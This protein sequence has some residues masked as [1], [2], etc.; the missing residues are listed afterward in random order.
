MLLKAALMDGAPAQ[1]CWKKWKSMVDIDNMDG[2]SYRLIPLLHYNLTQLGVQDNI[3]PR[4][5]GISRYH[6][7]KNHILLE[8][9]SSLLKMLDQNNIEVMLLKGSALINQYYESPA[10]RPMSDIDIMV[11]PKKLNETIA[12]LKNSGWVPTMDFDFTDIR[13]QRARHSQEYRD[14]S[15]SECDLHWTP[16]SSGTWEGAELRFW[17]TSQE[18]ILNGISAR[19]LGPT[20]QLFHI[21]IHGGHYNIFPAI[22]WVADS[23][24]ILNKDKDRIDWNLLINMAD[25]YLSAAMIVH[26]LKYLHDDF[27]V[28]IPSHALDII[29]NKKIPLHEIIARKILSRPTPLHRIDL[30]LIKAWIRHS[31]RWHGKSFISRLLSFPDFFRILVCAPRWRDVPSQIKPFFRKRY[32]S[33]KD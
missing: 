27:N 19:T 4:L 25:Q 32:Q 18:I 10:L 12:I 2:A 17:E 22:R 33:S 14:E 28:D 21:L 20:E 26:S 24:Y 16:I 6:W 29:N 15:G 7:C 31:R 5:K 30:L 13:S 11:R 9:L 1:Q 23:V 3:M 8:K